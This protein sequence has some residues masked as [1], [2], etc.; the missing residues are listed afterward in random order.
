MQIKLAASK[1]KKIDNPLLVGYKEIKTAP[2]VQ[3]KAKKNIYCKRVLNQRKDNS[4]ERNL[5]KSISEKS[6]SPIKKPALI[7]IL[8]KR[9][10]FKDNFN[11]LT[12]I[13]STKPNATNYKSINLISSYDATG[14]PNNKTLNGFKKSASKVMMVNTGINTDNDDDMYNLTTDSNIIDATNKKD[15]IHHISSSYNPIYT[16]ESYNDTSTYNIKER[17]KVKSILRPVRPI[18]GNSKTMN[19]LNSSMSKIS[20]NKK[21]KVIKE[22]DSSGLKKLCKPNLLKYKPVIKISDYI[23]NKLEENTLK[24]YNLKRVKSVDGLSRLKEN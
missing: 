9:D 17:N 21:V 24:E 3:K 23:K 8:N 6:A 19:V 4:E 7:S 14:Y 15:A 2:V 11:I 22:S 13:N 10:S 18:T 16:C 5:P 1:E 12:T 20:S